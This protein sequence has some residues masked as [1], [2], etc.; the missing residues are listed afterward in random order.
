MA[1][2][3]EEVKR[4][5]AA[6]D[7][8]MRAANNTLNA[9][10]LG[11]ETPR[12]HADTSTPTDA[13]YPTYKA[14]NT[15][16]DGQLEDAGTP[17]DANKPTYA[18]G[19]TTTDGQPADRP[20]VNSTIQMDGTNTLSGSSTGAPMTDRSITPTTV[21]QNGTTMG[22]SPASSQ[23]IPQGTSKH[24]AKVAK[25]TSTKHANTSDKTG[26]IAQADDVRITKRRTD[27]SP[28]PLRH[29]K[30]SMR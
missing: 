9:N 16:T 20:E 27:I 2:V 24:T 13:N 7:R 30:I 5:H 29:G 6:H 14:G 17:T 12:G 11:T 3:D 1:A 21:G 22:I 26:S 23:A 18:V 15:T 4:I 25:P 28:K 8:R 10:S 19:K